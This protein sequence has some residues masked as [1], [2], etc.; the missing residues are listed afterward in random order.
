MTRHLETEGPETKKTIVLYPK[1]SS[2][3]K[4][5]SL[6]GTRGKIPCRNRGK[7]TNPSCSFWHPPV[8]QN[9]KSES[10]Y[11]KS[12]KCHFRHVEADE[13]P[14]KKSK[15]GGA[16]GSVALLNE[17]AQLGCISRFL[18]EKICST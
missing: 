2:S 10:G 14:S 3:S 13:K 17:S 6:S 1:K 7:C 11:K 9:C 18:S 8:C 12:S 16:K 4:G 5:A 15:K